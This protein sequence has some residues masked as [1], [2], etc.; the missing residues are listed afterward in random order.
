MPA[1]AAPPAGG[2]P[3]PEG[4]DPAAAP[5]G[6]LS[7]ATVGWVAPP[8]EPIA[9]GKP[10][11]VIAGV[12]ARLGAYWLDS[13][14]L[15]LAYVIVLFVLVAVTGADLSAGSPTGFAFSGPMTFAV[16]VV[17]T[18]LYFLY[19]VGF[20]TSSAKATPGMRLFKLQIAN[21]ADGKRLDIGPAVIRWVAL[22]GLVSLLFVIPEVGTV[23]SLV[24][25][26]WVI[27]LLI[28]T[29]NDGMHQG[30]HDRW[31]KSVIVRPESATT[32]S[33]AWFATCLIVIVI[34]GFFFLIPIIALILLGDQVSTIL[35]SV[36]ES[37]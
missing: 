28:S 7:A 29:A 5:A 2:A 15:A 34:V 32:S 10:G 24:G 8:P 4:G 17:A 18:G 30:F 33:G 22:G 16:Y 21:A 9:T 35:S 20:W 19:F 14:V 37:V 25:T 3:A 23:A 12:G 1:G 36:G 26:V 13:I 27:A 11:W 6:V 31:A